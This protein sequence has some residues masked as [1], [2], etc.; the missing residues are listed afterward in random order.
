MKK[1][2]LFLEFLVLATLISIS[3]TCPVQAWMV[4]FNWINPVYEGYDDFLGATVMAYEEATTATLAVNIQNH[5]AEDANVTVTVQM[6]WETGNWTSKTEIPKGLSR[7]F[8]LDISIPS[9]AT[10]SNLVTHAYTITVEYNR[11]GTVTSEEETHNNFAV[12]SSDQADA[13]LLREKVETWMV[14]YDDLPAPLYLPSEAR[15]LWIEA[16]VEEEM[17]DEDYDT[18]G[19][20]TGAKIHYGN[21][22]DLIDEAL[23]SEVDKTSSFEDALLGL[24]NS[25]GSYLSMQGYGYMII[26]VGF[27]IGFLL[28]GIGVVIYLVRKS[29]QPPTEA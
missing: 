24:I 7:V 17:A 29:K 18:Y 11:T 16:A 12:Y 1:S 13:R 28:M 20:F 10:A 5:Y 2:V 15:K 9:T 22:L 8:E 21:A 6:D 26:G 3:M 19:N 25:A 27:G 4:S 23:S 14:I